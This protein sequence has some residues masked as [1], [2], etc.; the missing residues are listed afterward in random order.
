MIYLKK[1]LKMLLAIAT[2]FIFFASLLLL[3]QYS[4]ASGEKKTNINN[5]GENLSE[6]YIIP[7]LVGEKYSNIADNNIIKINEEYNDDFNEGYVIS[8]S[9]PSGTKKSV[10][11][12]IEVTVSKGTSLRTLPDIE[13]KSI[14]DAIEQL[15]S[16]GFTPTARR[17]ENNEKNNIVLGYSDGYKPGDS[18]R[19]D[20]K[21][22]IDI[23]V[24]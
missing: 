10:N 1:T 20:K 22:S 23:A 13:G 7:N 19:I 15:S 14:S 5:D 17:I 16:L 6:S 4:R 3:T 12:V 11:D 2:C 18:A 9:I 8:Q 24:N 21:I